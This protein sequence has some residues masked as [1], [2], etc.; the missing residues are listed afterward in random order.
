MPTNLR[1]MPRAVVRLSWLDPH[2]YVF[3]GEVRKRKSLVN[4]GF[5]FVPQDSEDQILDTV[6][7]RCE[8]IRKQ[9]EGLR[10]PAEVSAHHKAKCG[11]VHLR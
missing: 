10:V 9:T 2:E 4:G 5:K 6:R 1:L 7:T 3:V 11:A 8:N